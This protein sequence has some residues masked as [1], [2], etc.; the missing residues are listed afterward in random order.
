M[1]RPVSRL[2]P[3][4]DP[5][6]FVTAAGIRP[7]ARPRATRATMGRNPSAKMNKPI[8]TDSTGL[9]SQSSRSTRS[10]GESA[11]RRARP[12]RLQRARGPAAAIRAAPRAGMPRMMIGS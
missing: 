2:R 8:R 3:L 5:R 11:S 12:S 7:T 9:V 1:M 6:P 10:R 4:A